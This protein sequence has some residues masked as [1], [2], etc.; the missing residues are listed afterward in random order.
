MRLL[1]MRRTGS[2][3]ALERVAEALRR[4]PEPVE[5]PD[6]AAVRV[7]E[8]GAQQVVESERAGVAREQRV[9][10][11]P[12]ARRRRGVD[13]RRAEAAAR[14]LDVEAERRRGA[15][16]AIASSRCSLSMLRE[17]WRAASSRARISAARASTDS[18]GARR[19]AGGAVA[20]S[21]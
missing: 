10:R 11:R 4:D 9:Q 1:P 19:G 6:R 18:A 2:A 5:Q 16:R 15:V 14:G 12:E 3:W 13:R 20:R 21:R 17:P 7:L 8:R